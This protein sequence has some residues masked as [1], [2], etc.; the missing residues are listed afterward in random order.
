MGR[1]FQMLS[2]SLDPAVDTPEVLKRYAEAWGNKKGWLYLTG[3]AQDVT[4][5]RQRMG[6]YEPDASLDAEK[7][8]HTGLVTFG[9]DKTGRWAALPT[10]MDSRDLARA[11][12]RV[13]RP[14][15]GR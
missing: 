10:G 5:L 6:L 7:I 12:L 11:I 3:S 8:S 9:N 2:I 1:D 13:T 14:I 4:L 15:G